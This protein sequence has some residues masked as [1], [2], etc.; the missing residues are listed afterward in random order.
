MVWDNERSNVVQYL[1]CL[2]E[3]FSLPTLILILFGGSPRF[4]KS[5]EFKPNEY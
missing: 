4:L 5:D 1:K 2:L 3:E